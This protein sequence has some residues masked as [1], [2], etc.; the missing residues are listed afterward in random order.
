MC[1]MFFMKEGLPV[2]YIGHSTVRM[3][4]WPNVYNALFLLCMHRSHIIFISFS[5]ICLLYSCAQIGLFCDIAFVRLSARVARRRRFVCAL[6][7]RRKAYSRG[8]RRYRHVRARS[9]S[10]RL[11]SRSRRLFLRTAQCICLYGRMHRKGAIR[12]TLPILYNTMTCAFFFP[13]SI[14]TLGGF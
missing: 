6:S 11:S 8:A 12:P 2:L 14:F 1:I 5:G 3:G 13:F 10:R 9:P 4:V 7:G